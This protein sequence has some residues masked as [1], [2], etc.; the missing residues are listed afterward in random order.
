MMVVSETFLHPS[1][2]HTMLL[3]L[4]AWRSAA[5]WVSAVVRAASS[6]CWTPPHSQQRTRLLLHGFTQSYE[7]AQASKTLGCGHC[8]IYIYAFNHFISLGTIQKMFYNK[9]FM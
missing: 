1:I 9:Q 7:I 2:R 4:Q 6:Q 3:L 5:C 8:S